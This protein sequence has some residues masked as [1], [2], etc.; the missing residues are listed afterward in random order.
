MIEGLESRQKEQ[1]PRRKVTRL[2]AVMAVEYPGS[3]I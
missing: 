2:I 1:R 3:A